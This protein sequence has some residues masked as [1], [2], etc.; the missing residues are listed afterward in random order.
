MTETV[1][2]TPAP[3]VVTE[4]AQ[5]TGPTCSQADPCSMTLDGPQF[6]ALGFGLL[7]LVLCGFAVLAAQLKRP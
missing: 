2:E 4:T 5:P 6:A 3:V 1:T 7:L